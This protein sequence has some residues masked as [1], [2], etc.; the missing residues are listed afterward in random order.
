MLGLNGYQKTLPILF[1]AMVIVPIAIYQ[2]G[3]R[4][5]VLSYG[6]PAKTYFKPAS[7]MEGDRIE[8]CFDDVT[9][10]RL[11]RGRL[12]THLTPSKGP[13]M[14]LDDYPIKTPL[15]TGKVT[16]KC[17]AWTVPD[18][19]SDREAGTATLHGYAENE[20]W[21]LDHWVPIVRPLPS[22]KLEIRKRN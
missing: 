9:W 8:L 19:G 2:W 7:A 17:R 18:L 20:C 12:V 22:V 10:R 3:M 1:I 4:G 6:D 11:C 16:P 14:D 15:A 13:R 21:P 5:D